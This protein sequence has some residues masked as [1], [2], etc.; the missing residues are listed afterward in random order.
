MQTVVLQQTQQ[1]KQP[2][3]LRMHERWGAGQR[4][5]KRIKP[6]EIWVSYK[7]RHAS[8]STSTKTPSNSHVMM[9]VLE[10]LWVEYLLFATISIPVVIHFPWHVVRFAFLLISIRH[11]DQCVRRCSMSRT[12]DGMSSN[13]HLKLMNHLQVKTFTPQ[14]INMSPKEGPFQQKVSSS[15]HWFSNMFKGYRLVFCVL[16]HLKNILGISFIPPNPNWDI[17]VPST[18]HSVAQECHNHR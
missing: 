16:V 11:S 13:K 2:E 18:K 14:K 4:C 10:L 8:D 9:I 3:C 1:H 5:P 15:N 6:S 12:N 17:W 7:K